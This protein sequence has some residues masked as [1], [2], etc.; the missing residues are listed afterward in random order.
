MPVTNTYSSTNV[1]NE[2]N[3]NQESNHDGDKE[4]SE[5]NKKLSFK[6]DRDSKNSEEN[7]VEIEE[8]D[9]KENRI[10]EVSET[11]SQN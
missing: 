7:P 5:L 2:N 10:M 9:L 8:V 6:E 4:N 1:M 3:S 11:S